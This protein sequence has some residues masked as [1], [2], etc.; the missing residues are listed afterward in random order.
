LEKHQNISWWHKQNDSGKD[1]FAVEYFDTKEKKERLFYPDFIIKTVD[2]KIYLVDTK[3]DATAKST[4]TKDKAE[5]L[6][7][8]IKENQDKYELEIIGGIV[9]SKY[10][11]WLIHFSDV[12]IYENSDDWN[13]FLN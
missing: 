4:E 5:A 13:I 8:W 9:I 7:K 10:P 3:K 1:N 12:Y 6:Q 2:N 11:N